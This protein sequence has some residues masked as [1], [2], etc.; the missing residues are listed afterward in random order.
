MLNAG[1]EKFAVLGEPSA[2]LATRQNSNVKI[3]ASLGE[4]WEESLGG[5][6]FP[7]ASL[8]VNDRFISGGKNADFIEWL[9]ERLEE[10]AAWVV[11]SDENAIDAGAAIK[12]KGSLVNAQFDKQMIER[13]NIRAIRASEAKQPLSQYFSVLYAQSPASL[14]GTLPNIETL[15]Y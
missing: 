5:S 8:I 6:F 10:G 13:C 14:G 1:T 4:L 12:A 9:L 11:E 15:C 2:T 3:L 7:Q